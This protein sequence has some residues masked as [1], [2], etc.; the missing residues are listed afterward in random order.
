MGPA[1]KES[2]K[3]LL[4]VINARNQAWQKFLIYGVVRYVTLALLF[5]YTLVLDKKIVLSSK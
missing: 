2:F 4:G 3:D 5:F 1:E